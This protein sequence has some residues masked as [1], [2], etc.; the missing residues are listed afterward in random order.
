MDAVEKGM[1][2]A[3]NVE[4]CQLRPLIARIETVHHDSL[5]V[6]W[7]EGSYT[8]GWK[9][10][11]KKDGRNLIEWTDTVPKSSIILFDFQLTKSNRLRKA[12]V[13]HLKQAYAKL[14]D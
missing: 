13:E 8:R 9:V 5:D 12:T 11:K 2:V 10:A 1:L 6:V 7:L 14:D 3:L 4:N